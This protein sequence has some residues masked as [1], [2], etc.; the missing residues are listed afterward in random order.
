MPLWIGLSLALVGILTAIFASRR[1]RF[2]K[3]L[4]PVI[5]AE[6]ELMHDENLFAD[7][8][9]YMRPFRASVSEGHRD[10]NRRST[11]FWENVQTIAILAAAVG[12]AFVVVGLF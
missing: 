3:V 1:L 4:E 2:N 9:D 5:E 6:V 7:E 10:D 8:P 11:T 12:T